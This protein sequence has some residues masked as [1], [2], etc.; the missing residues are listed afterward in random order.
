MRLMTR[1]QKGR[2]TSV[3]PDQHSENDAGLPQEEKL[4]LGR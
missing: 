3:P 1:E 2:G 4:S